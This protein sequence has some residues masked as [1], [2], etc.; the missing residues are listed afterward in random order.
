M[1]LSKT[2]PKQCVWLTL[3]NMRSFKN[4]SISSPPLPCWAGDA[5]L[6]LRLGMPARV[7]LGAADG[8]STPATADPGMYLPP[9]T[10]P[11]PPSR[12]L[13]TPCPS[14]QG[15]IWVLREKMLEVPWGPCQA[16]RASQTLS[17]GQSHPQGWEW[18]RQF[19]SHSCLC[20]MAGLTSQHT[21]SC[22]VILS[23]YL[24]RWSCCF[25]SKNSF[26]SSFQFAYLLFHFLA[27]WMMG[28]F[29][30][31]SKCEVPELGWI[32]SVWGV[33]T[34]RV[35]RRRR[36]RGRVTLGTVSRLGVGTCGV[37]RK[38]LKDFTNRSNIWGWCILG[39]LANLSK[40]VICICRDKSD[41]FTTEGLKSCK[42][43]STLSYKGYS[44]W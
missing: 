20:P 26:I 17:L 14:C 32:C 5:A 15:S 43:Y 35:D 41:C 2:L 21:R 28:I 13:R 22:G 19:C 30:E 39:L 29:E 9:P 33:V 25:T 37:N 18:S 40:R 34:R 10:P 38:V 1:V 3:N 7:G 23:D 24:S 42:K 31:H 36:R 8:S 4:I 44:K 12:D 6:P 27:F 11:A 16:S